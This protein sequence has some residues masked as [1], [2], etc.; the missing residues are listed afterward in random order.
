MPCR[1]TGAARGPMCG[2]EKRSVP[3]RDPTS[4]LTVPLRSLRIL[5]DLC[6][7]RSESGSGYSHKARIDSG[8]A[9]ARIPFGS[10]TLRAA[11][12]RTSSH[13]MIRSLPRITR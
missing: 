9:T 4:F 2:R 3:S 5:C 6:V 12:M 13:S 10:S 11:K 1:L 7:R 8:I